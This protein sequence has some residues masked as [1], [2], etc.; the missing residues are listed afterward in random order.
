MKV[1]FCADKIY[2]SRICRRCDIEAQLDLLPHICQ[3]G[4]GGKEWRQ[5]YGCVYDWEQEVTV[6]AGA[7][8]ALLVVIMVCAGP[9][10]EVVLF[11]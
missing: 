1:I 10:D 4:P 6:T 2:H 11:F 9:G 5:M 7:M 8:Q 3:L